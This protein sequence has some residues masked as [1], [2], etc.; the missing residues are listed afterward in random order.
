MVKS[1]TARSSPDDLDREARNLL[2]FRHP[3]VV[4]YFGRDSTSAA[5]PGIVL[6]RLS[7]DLSKYLDR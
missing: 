6:E 1:P 3:N 4:Q 2:M 7:V 5:A